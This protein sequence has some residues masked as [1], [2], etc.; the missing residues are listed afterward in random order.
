MFCHPT[1]STISSNFWT[2]R[3]DWRRGT[4]SLETPAFDSS[5]HHWWHTWAWTFSRWWLE[6]MTAAKPIQSRSCKKVLLAGSEGWKARA[7]LAANCISPTAASSETTSPD[8]VAQEWFCWE[9]SLDRT[10]WDSFWLTE[11]I[12]RSAWPRRT[13]DLAVWALSWSSCFAPVICSSSSFFDRHS[14]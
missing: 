2:C 12:R 14:T 7:T 11:S 13:E 9:I 8:S 1:P 6:L 5:T 10:Q 4:W 3:S